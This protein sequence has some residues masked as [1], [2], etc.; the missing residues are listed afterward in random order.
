LLDGQSFA[1][2]GSTPVDDSTTGFAGHSLTKAM[3]S[4]SFDSARL[5]R[6]LHFFSFILRSSL[7]S[8]KQDGV[9]YF[10]H[11]PYINA[12]AIKD[13]QKIPFLI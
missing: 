7:G 4:C 12:A 3:G 9:I 13:Y 8:R 5:K 2:F 10:F 6:S 11:G 1:T